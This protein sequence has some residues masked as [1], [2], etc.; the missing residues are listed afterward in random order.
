MKPVH[1]LF[2]RDGFNWDDPNHNERAGT[3]NCEEK[4]KMDRFSM[5]LPAWISAIDKHGKL[6]TLEVVTRDI[7]AGGAFLQTDQPLS[8]GTNIE[9]NLVLPLSN[10]PNVQIR[11]SRIDVSGSVIRTESQG[12]AVC[13]DKRYQ[14]SPVAG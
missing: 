13:F 4:R 12:V 14:I 2:N 3:L 7:C 5:E 11:R 6:Q 1:F 10:I 8:V 9:M